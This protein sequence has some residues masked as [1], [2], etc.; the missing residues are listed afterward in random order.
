MPWPLD[1]PEA[2]EAGPRA[3]GNCRRSDEAKSQLQPHGPDGVSRAQ[4]KTSEEVLAREFS[5][6]H[7]PS[8]QRVDSTRRALIESPHVRT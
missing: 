2:S 7:V 5:T 6:P 3:H 4:S 1:G 8:S